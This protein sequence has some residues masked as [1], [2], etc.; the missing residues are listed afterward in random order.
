M[1]WN[2]LGTEVIKLTGSPL[3]IPVIGCNWIAPPGSNLRTW[4]VSEVP[5]TFVVL[6]LVVLGL[7][8]AVFFGALV[9][10]GFG[11]ILGTD[12]FGGAFVAGLLGL[13]FGFGVDATLGF[14]SVADFAPGFP[15]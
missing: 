8:E 15:F 10:V 12:F 13:G 6:G 14:D 7:F 9:F 3:N 5:L 2:R 1:V 11:A 4:S